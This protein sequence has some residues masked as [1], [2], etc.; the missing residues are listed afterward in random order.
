MK[1]QSSLSPSN[2]LRS[3]RK[4]ST[5]TSTTGSASLFNPCTRILKHLAEPQYDGPY[6]ALLC[7]AEVV[8]CWA[9]IHKVA[10][11]E[12]DWI[13]YMQ[14]VEGWWLHGEHDYRLLRGDTGPLVYPAGFLYLF[15]LLRYLTETGTNIRRAQHLFAAF[16]IIQSAIVLLIY[17]RVIRCRPRSV[18]SICPLI[19]FLM[20]MSLSLTLLLAPPMTLSTAPT[21][22]PLTV[23]QSK[24]LQ[25]VPARK[26][27]PVTLQPAL[28]PTTHPALQPQ[29]PPTLIS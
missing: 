23:R 2:S 21:L 20:L 24:E 26:H 25:F 1:Q 16:Y 28:I 22:V 4:T 18:T 14:E 12:I 3:S 13:A 27:S 17:S 11:T 7:L 15:T 19:L 8:L 9:I 5:S 29:L 6:V 10:Y